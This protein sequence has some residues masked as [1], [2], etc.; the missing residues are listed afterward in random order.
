MRNRKTYFHDLLRRKLAESTHRP[1]R[2]LNVASGP[3]RDVAE[4]CAAHGTEE[5]HFD[6]V[7]LD[8]KAIAYAQILCAPFERCVRFICVNALRFTT[9]IKYDL[10]WSAGL[11]DYLNDGL[12]VHLLKR[13]MRFT[14]EGGEL[15]VGNF[16]DF[17]PSRPYME[18]LGD[19]RLIQPQSGF[20]VTKRNPNRPN[21]K[22]P[23]HE[24]MFR[25][26]PRD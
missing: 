3:A 12:F 11:F 9:K 8:T 7:E 4:W 13:L 15:V 14:G 20:A 6:C 2:V 10:V 23:N 17:N 26:S 16:G 21:T 25:V 18:L 22:R 5:V 19:W 1:L 24:M